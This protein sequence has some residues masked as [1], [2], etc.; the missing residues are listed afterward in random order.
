MQFFEIMWFNA[1]DRLSG[2]F[3]CLF[4]EITV[5]IILTKAFQ[6]VFLKGEKGENED[7]VIV[8]Q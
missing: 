5:S 2:S 1:N 7:M 3:A 8:I 6:N 4:V